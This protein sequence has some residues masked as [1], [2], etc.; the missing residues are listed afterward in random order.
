MYSHFDSN[1]WVTPFGLIFLFAV[2]VA[3]WLARRNAITINVDGSHV[4]LL[5]PVTIIVGIAGGTVL[6]LLM[7]MDQMIAGEMMQTEVRIRLFGMLAASS[8]AVFIY[9]RIEK[10]SFRR[11]L[12]VFALPTI[13]GLMIHRIGCF[14]AGCCWGDIVSNEHSTSFSSQV[15]TLPFLSGLSSGVSYPPGSLP[16]EQHLALGL[17][18]PNSL[19]S[20]PVYPVQLYEGALLLVLLLALWRLPWQRFPK[21]LLVVVVVCAYAVIRFFI[22]Y[23]RADGP[24]VLGNMTGTQLQCLLLLLSGILLPGMLGITRG[25]QSANG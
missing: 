6:S 5:I 3:W 24:I 8:V 9:S 25:G 20:L 10:L 14:L 2:L 23:L 17:I 7:P 21:G 16:F 12:D 18:E 19:A 1:T 4:D 11:L 15:Q 22:E 13:A